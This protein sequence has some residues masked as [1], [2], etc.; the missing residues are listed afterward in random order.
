M[1]KTMDDSA[2][3]ESVEPVYI[4]PIS[5]DDGYMQ[6]DDVKRENSS[7]SKPVHDD[8]LQMDTNRV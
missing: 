1:P 3:Y 6:I 4:V 5:D 7:K 2:A 8:V